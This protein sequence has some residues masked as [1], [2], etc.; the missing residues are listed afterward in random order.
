MKTPPIQ[1]LSGKKRIGKDQP[2]FIVAEIGINHNGD[3][4]LACRMIDE[5]KRAGADSVKFQNYRTEDF[6]GDKSLTHT[7][8]SQGREISESQ[9]EMFRRYELNR[10]QLF[11]LSQY[12]HESGLHFF[13]TPT[14]RESLD[15][16]IATGC[17][18][19][20]NG[21]DF[22]VNHRLIKQMAASNIPTVLSTGMSTLAEIDEAVRVFRQSGGSEIILLH[23]TSSYPTPPED[24][25]LSRISTL[26][27]AFG[28]HVGFSDHSWGSA[29]AIGSVAF[30]S[31]FI[32]KH[33]TTD[34]SLPGPDHRFSSDPVEFKQLV[35]GVRAMEKC[36][37]SPEI[38][39][40]QSE[41]Y[42]RKNFR[43]SCVAATEL[44]EGHVITESD[45]LFHRPAGG[46]HP[47]NYEA[48]IGKIT[49]CT[50]KA[51]QQFDFHLLKQA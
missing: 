17:D 47:R 2:V 41:E 33:F 30:G 1:V 14:G 10:E 39:P 6:L 42:G 28:T 43:L 11:L 20:K 23:C 46:I 3:M 45:I 50:L 4:D 22:L 21:S 15:D 34:K 48:I 16:L 18:L 36:I 37:G 13:S 35:D 24:V 51:G 32:E 19:L 31:C 9:F 49:S 27:S 29:A 25:N 38:S 12:C 44:P 7:Y 40:T 5:A 26:E 8:I